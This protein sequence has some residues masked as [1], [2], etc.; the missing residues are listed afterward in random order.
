MAGYTNIEGLIKGFVHA[1][2]PTRDDKGLAS[3]T[4]K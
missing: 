3:Q 4:G 1:R 2:V